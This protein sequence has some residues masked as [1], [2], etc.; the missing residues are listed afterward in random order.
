MSYCT[1]YIAIIMNMDHNCTV[2]SKSFTQFGFVPEGP[3][4]IWKGPSAHHKLIPVVIT[5]HSLI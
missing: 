5:T 2:E 4:K 3:L 1:D